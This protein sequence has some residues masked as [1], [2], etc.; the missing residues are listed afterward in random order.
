MTG[1]CV[2]VFY[3]AQNSP[4]NK[5]PTFVCTSGSIKHT[6]RH[7][8]VSVTLHEKSIRVCLCWATTGIS[9]VIHLISQDSSRIASMNY[10]VE[11]FPLCHIKNLCLL[12]QTFFLNSTIGAHLCSGSA[13]QCY[14]GIFS[15]LWE[16]EALLVKIAL[17]SLKPSPTRP[18]IFARCFLT[19]WSVYFWGEESES[20]K[21]SSSSREA[22][23]GVVWI[24]E[25]LSIVCAL[26]ITDAWCPF[27]EESC[28]WC[29][30]FRNI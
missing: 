18:K 1:G 11:V 4:R 7:T 12:V 10:P 2:S 5:E 17:K 23:A 22:S 6:C 30:N 14:E 24:Y 25:M 16:A 19:I 9:T 27:F 29:R 3:A 21:Q 28:T 8:A 15:V 13:S 20:S 26:Q